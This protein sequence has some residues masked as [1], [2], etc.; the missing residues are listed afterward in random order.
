MNFKKIAAIIAGVL[1][2]VGLAG[3]GKIVNQ[4]KSPVKQVNKVLTNNSFSNLIVNTD[5]CDVIIK[6]GKL[7]KVQYQGDKDITPKVENKNGQLIIKQNG[8]SKGNPVI[9]ITIPE[10]VSLNQ[11]DIK[12][13][14]GDITVNGANIQTAQFNTEEGNAD[15]AKTSMNDGQV[16]SEE[17]DITLQSTSTKSGITVKAEQGDVNVSNCNFKGYDLTTEE[18]SISMRGHSYASSTYKKHT[19][20]KNLLKVESE[21]GDITVK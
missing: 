14:E 4:G 5:A 19:H 17:G 7:Y 11:A 10:N 9:R 18:G 1:V 15:I 21:E 13:E 2:I 6:T 20:E 3:C 16:N 8:S 12:S